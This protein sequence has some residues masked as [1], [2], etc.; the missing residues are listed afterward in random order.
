M[1]LFRKPKKIETDSI[2]PEGL[3]GLRPLEDSTFLYLLEQAVEGKME[4]Y[5]AAVPFNLV[6]PFDEKFN[7]S[8]HP[9]GAAAINQT[10]MA[11]SKGHVQPCWVYPRAGKFI[12]SDDYI[13]YYAAI[14]G[15]PDYLPCFIVGNPQQE[16]VK[17]VQGPLSKDLVLKHLGFT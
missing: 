14:E 16:G 5:F 11:W 4:V 8:L 2:S 1:G 6:Q 12:L 17:E 7:P 9:A 13:T 15:Q 3:P 10:I